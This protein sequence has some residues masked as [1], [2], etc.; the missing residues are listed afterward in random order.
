MFKG[1]L[2]SLLLVAALPQVVSAANNCSRLF[3]STQNPSENKAIEIASRYFS[4]LEGTREYGH[5]VD[6]ILESGA[7]PT[8]YRTRDRIERAWRQ[9]RTSSFGNGPWTIA[10][11]ES[12]LSSWGFS[13]VQRTE[14]G[15]GIGERLFGTTWATWQ[16]R[17]TGKIVEVPEGLATGHSSPPMSGEM[18]SAFLSLMTDPSVVRIRLN[19]TVHGRYVR[20]SSTGD[21]EIVI[22][23]IP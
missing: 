6:A 19:Q 4:D 15:S 7:V 1:L 18:L 14:K 23:R 10:V 16:D 2:F 3:S 17:F 20:T 13:V 22:E 12:F 11:L 9:S 8:A 21:R 5:L